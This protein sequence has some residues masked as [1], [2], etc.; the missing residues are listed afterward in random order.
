M[1]FIGMLAMKMPM[2]MSYHLWLTLGSLGV[3]VMAS[4]LA[5]NIAIPG[6]SL[7]P[8]RLIFA[9]L[10]LSTGVVS[11]HYV[12]M[13][14]LMVKGGILWDNRFVLLSVGIAVA[15]SGVALWLAFHLRE[16]RKGIFINRLA[17]PL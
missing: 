8:L 6:Q 2:I 10:I 16:K 11:M 14:A 5:I 13:A 17:A 7:S 1:H 9:T 15:A 12:G 4:T 3:A